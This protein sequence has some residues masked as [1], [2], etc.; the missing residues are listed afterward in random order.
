MKPNFRARSIDFFKK[1]ARPTEWE[2]E[3]PN[4]RQHYMDS[5][6]GK[7]QRNVYGKSKD[8]FMSR[9]FNRRMKMGDTFTKVLPS[10]NHV[11]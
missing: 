6:I 3:L 2:R 7:H 5:P 1:T 10:Y 11:A 8:A 9:T 4:D